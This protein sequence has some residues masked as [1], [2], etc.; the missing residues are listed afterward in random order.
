MTKLTDEQKEI[1]ILKA[2]V[3]AQCKQIRRYQTP[4]PSSPE[5]VFDTFAEARLF[6]GVRNISEI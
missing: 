6:Y 1:K 2:L 3:R 5:W 4:M